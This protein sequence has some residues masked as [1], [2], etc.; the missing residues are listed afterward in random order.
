[1]SKE[2]WYKYLS[3]D[4]KSL[5]KNMKFELL[6]TKSAMYLLVITYIILINIS[7]FG[8]FAKFSD[9]YI[10]GTLMVINGIILLLGVFGSSHKL[11]KHIEK[12]ETDI[13]VLKNN[14]KKRDNE[15]YFSSKL[16]KQG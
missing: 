9:N 2:R 8:G 3:D 14:G 15:A 1:M 7:I 5:M 4:E 12:T 13:E 16:T 6:A 11:T 10:V